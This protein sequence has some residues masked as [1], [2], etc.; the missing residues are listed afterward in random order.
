MLKLYLQLFLT[1]GALFGALGCLA[2]LFLSG[3]L[4]WQLSQAGKE[5]VVNWNKI[6]LI[7]IAFFGCSAGF[8]YCL[9][10]VKE[11]KKESLEKIKHYSNLK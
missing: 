4:F 9:K 8:F 7:V 11:T 6:A 3:I 5:F 2:W 1:L 10:W